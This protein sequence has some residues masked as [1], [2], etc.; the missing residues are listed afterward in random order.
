MLKHAYPYP[1][2]SPLPQLPTS[3]CKYC[4]VLITFPLNWSSHINLLCKKARKVSA[5]IFRLCLF[6]PHATP[7]PFSYCSMSHLFLT[8]PTAPPFNWDPPPNISFDQ[9]PFL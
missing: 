1:K 3:S 6:Y 2:P 8:F 5:Q 9:F 7:P 4:G